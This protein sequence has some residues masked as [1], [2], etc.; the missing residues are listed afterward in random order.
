MDGVVA[1]ANNSGGN[2]N[3][4]GINM[5]VFKE[6]RRKRTGDKKLTAN[7]S[8]TISTGKSIEVPGETV[9]IS[10]AIDENTIQQR[11]SYSFRH[12]SYN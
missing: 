5:G 8:I 12:T 9:F 1:S 7:G 11:W 6:N 3:P 4:Y 10:D 2:P